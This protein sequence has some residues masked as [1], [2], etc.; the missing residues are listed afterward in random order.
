MG[1]RR[2]SIQSIRSRNR[3]KKRV[4]LLLEKEFFLVG[5][6]MVPMLLLFLHVV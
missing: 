2:E 1:L 5:L 4:R 6:C 3:E